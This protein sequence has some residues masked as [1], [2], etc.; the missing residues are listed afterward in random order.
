M[1]GQKLLQLNPPIPLETPKGWGWAHFISNE[2]IEQSIY[3]TVFI[4][5]TGE[6][7]TFPNEQ[8]RAMKNI[9]AERPSPSKPEIPKNP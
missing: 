1:A 4:S 5:E 9:T 8:V 6:I 3:W 2:S 7:W